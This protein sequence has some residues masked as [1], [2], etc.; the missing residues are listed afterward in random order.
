MSMTARLRE[1]HGV[2][3][4]PRSWSARIGVVGIGLILLVAFFG[5][6]AA[7]H[8]PSEIV[9]PPFQAVS[10]DDP[11]G[12]DHL[13]R[14]VLSRVLWGGS[15]LIGLAVAATLAAYLIGIPIG[16][17]SG[18]SR[19]LA[20]PILMRSM[21]VLLAFPPL[22][23][24]LVLVTGTGPGSVALVV[25]AALVNLPGIA[26]IVRAATLEVSVRGYVEAAVARGE[27]MYS[28]LGKEVVPNITG[29]LF[30]DVGVRLTLS[31]LLIAAVT[32]LGLGPPPPAANWALMLNENRAG[33]TIQPWVIV[34]PAL[35]IATLTIAVNLVADAIAR[36]RGISIVERPQ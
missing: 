21:D 15:S 11:L 36:S 4:W 12:T 16:L 10:W 35:L 17:V 2:L 7:P 20:D 27:R 23:F 29:P 28:V 26:R 8:S 6:L 25:G 19:S 13:G 32:F 5:P 34:V 22:L 14:D 24:L 1:L 30:A 9:G 18:Y 33:I 31:I 3:R